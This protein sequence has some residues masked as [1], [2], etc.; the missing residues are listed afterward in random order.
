[1]YKFD[2]SITYKQTL[3]H[4]TNPNLH[5]TDV[6]KVDLGKVAIDFFKLYT[7]GELYSGAYFENYG[8][9]SSTADK[10]ISMGV[11]NAETL[12]A[13]YLIYRVPDT[14]VIRVLSTIQ[15]CSFWCYVM[16]EK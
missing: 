2:G 11:S 9:D 8:M 16:Y 3:S 13:D 15:N 12:G 4:I 5:Y 14:E 10:I 1:M 7:F 6:V